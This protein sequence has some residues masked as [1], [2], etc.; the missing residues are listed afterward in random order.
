MAKETFTWV[1]DTTYT[2]A[3]GTKAP[4]CLEKGRTYPAAEFP[5]AVLEEWAKTGHIKFAG[6]DKT[7]REE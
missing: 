7:G 6:R 3:F 4:A 2:R 5:A 1:A